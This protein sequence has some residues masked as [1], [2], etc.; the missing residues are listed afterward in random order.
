MAGAS[1]VRICI[2][3]SGQQFPDHSYRQQIGV[4]ADLI[5]DVRCLHESHY[6]FI[7]SKIGQCQ[8]LAS[9]VSRAISLFCSQCCQWDWISEHTTKLLARCLHKVL[10]MGPGRCLI[11][12]H[13]HPELHVLFP[14]MARYEVVWLQIPWW[15]SVGS[16]RFTSPFSRWTS[17]KTPD[18]IVQLSGAISLVRSQS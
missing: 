1:F 8:D 3:G 11:G 10:G 18:L 9:E 16:S 14:D 13:L 7:W 2:L 12:L 5:G 6:S 17:D 4:N 15:I